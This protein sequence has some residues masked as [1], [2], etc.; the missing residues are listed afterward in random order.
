[1]DG[2]SNFINWFKKLFLKK[3][4]Y[5]LCDGPAILFADGH[6]SHI[7]LELVYTANEHNVHL[8]CLLL[9]HIMQPLD[10]SVFYPLKGAYS[11]ILKECNTDTLAVNITKAIFS[12]ILRKVWDV[13]F[14]PSHLC[15]S[16]RATRIHP[17]NREAISGGK[18]KTDIPFK[19]PPKDDQTTASTLESSLST[20]ASSP[21]ILQGECNNCGFKLIPL[22]AHITVLFTE[23]LQMTKRCYQN[24]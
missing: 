3:V 11:N 22:W 20:V 6:H 18:L 13:S 4:E 15:S 9:T 24:Y 5:L 19:E 16:F 8:M 17:L 2:G 21:L 10:V 14:L 23:V 12:T 1:M 7:D